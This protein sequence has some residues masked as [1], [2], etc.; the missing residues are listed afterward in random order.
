MVGLALLLAG[1]ACSKKAADTGWKAEIETIDGVRTIRNPETPRY[2]TF[3]F[4][5]I[6]DLA[7]GQEED[8]A[9]FFPGRA[10]LNVDDQ[11]RFYV[12]DWGNRRSRSTMRM[13]FI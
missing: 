9:Y 1:L 5:L 2:G 11:G 8:E 6:E 7:I 12:C 10:E 3:A 4:D 13:G